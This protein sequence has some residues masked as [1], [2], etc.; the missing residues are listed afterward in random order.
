MKLL[1]DE[2][3]YMQNSLKKQNRSEARLDGKTCVIT[4]ATSGVG[5]HS[6]RRLA[7][8]GA[9]VVML[10]RNPEKARKV[11]DELSREFQAESDVFI[12]DMRKLAEVA[13]QPPKS[14]KNIPKLT[15]W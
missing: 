6:A 2:L 10:C 9:R 5:Y 15:F 3:E 14:R 11:Q 12:A 1:P 7:K 13:R 8:A 4:G